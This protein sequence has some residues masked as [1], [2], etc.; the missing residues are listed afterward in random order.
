MTT[1]PMTSLGAPGKW[2]WTLVGVGI[3]AVLLAASWRVATGAE[4]EA[5]GKEWSI[6]VAEAADS[7]EH[8]RTQLEAD[9]RQA[10]DEA[11]KREVYW[12]GQ[13]VAARAQC[14]QIAAT[15]LPAP[16]PFANNATALSQ[17]S[18]AQAARSTAD[19]RNIAN[20]IASIRV[21]PF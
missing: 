17:R 3:L 2:F 19:V 15:P 11:N 7:L 10:R 6:K 16:P 5:K 1:I 20:E 12:N 4:L 9:A 14:P 8:A 13:V 18:L 21:R